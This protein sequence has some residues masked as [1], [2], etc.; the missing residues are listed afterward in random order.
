MSI[1]SPTADPE[2]DAQGTPTSRRERP[3]ITEEVD[4]PLDDKSDICGGGHHGD[5]PTV[6]TIEEKEQEHKHKVEVYKNVIGGI[7]IA[8]CFG[9]IVIF[10]ILDALCEIDS[11]LF[12]GAFEFAKTIATA[13]I[14]YLFATN[15][16]K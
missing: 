7:L 16:K 10:S 2:I 15:A 11:T 3:L 13:I 6:K 8:V 4:R 1:T 12:A 9:I 5:S 14:G